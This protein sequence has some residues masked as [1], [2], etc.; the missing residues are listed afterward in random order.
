MHGGIKYLAYGDAEH[1]RGQKHEDK[2]LFELLEV[3]PVYALL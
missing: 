2:G 3:L 1:G